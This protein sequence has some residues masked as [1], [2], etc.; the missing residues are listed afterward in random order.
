MLLACVSK[1]KINTQNMKKFYFLLAF[2]FSTA[3]FLNAQIDYY[4]TEDGG[5]IFQDINDNGLV[6]TQGVFFDYTTETITNI[7][8]DENVLAL[9]GYNNAEDCAGTMI[10]DADNGIG[11]PAYR[12][13]G[14]WIP[15]GFIDSEGVGA[16]NTE[17]TA[18]GI[19]ENS[20]Y[21]TGL[22]WTSDFNTF[23]YRYNT[24]TDVM[25]KI[26]N[27]NV[28][29]SN[30]SGYS[31]NDAGIVVGW[32]ENSDDDNFIGRIP[33]YFD[34]TFHYIQPDVLDGGE[35][36]GIN[37][38]N[39]VVGHK[40]G[41]PFIYDIDLD[42]FTQFE[43]PFGFERGEF[44]SI[45]EDGIAVGFASFV[46]T[47]DF[48]P[49]TV[50]ETIIYHPSL[51]NNPILLR[52]ILEAQ[53]ITFDSLDGYL[54]RAT[55]ISPNGNFICGFHNPPA[56]KGWVIN[57]NDSLF[58][59]SDCIIAT[60]ATIEEILPIDGSSAAVDYNLEIEC[61]TSTSDDLQIVQI[62]GLPSG[63]LFPRGENYVEYHLVDGEGNIIYTSTF[64]VNVRD[65]YCNTI[66][67]DLFLVEP[68][69]RVQFEDIDN[70]TSADIDGSDGL[71]YFVEISTDIAQ[72]ESYDITI[73][74]NT[75]GDFDSNITVFV[76]WNQ[77]LI[78]DD[79][80]E[81]FEIGILENSTGTDGQQVVGQIT[82]PS[83]ATMGIT[84]MRVL[85]AFPNSGY[86]I[87]ACNPTFLNY[88]QIEDYTVNVTDA[89]SVN[90][91]DLNTVSIYPNP[92]NDML[93]LSSRNTIEQ[94]SIHNIL[95]Q[96]VIEKKVH[97]LDI[98]VN[99]SSLE[100]GVYLVNVQ[101]EYGTAQSFKVVKD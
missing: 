97:A 100:S 94:V 69:T 35:A 10:F 6:I 24:V 3:T 43:V 44:L 83:D 16:E 93:Y 42:T 40:S 68:I 74:A 54:G 17:S 9:S 46:D 45:S 61:G 82:V 84:R 63:S 27:D 88:G 58:S 71:E 8:A 62:E 90:G 98:E 81:I 19:S 91:N 39:Q 50:I 15:L 92:V 1:L 48:F 78:L 12:K 87:E 56:T 32:S 53:G 52:D 41:K 38:N 85:K 7:D 14:V 95:G 70:V 72:G 20:E 59:E 66:D 26:V 21:V 89:L 79:E 57:L 101:S 76:D 65:P 30:G 99:T 67:D 22:Y 33:F 18:R 60:P 86:F 77:N 29:S 64:N 34:G 49:V 13:D 31:V 75:G 23:P 25:E 37:N 11:Q 80:G 51:G 2:A 4:Q 47:S 36:Y 55:S 96:L 28:V 5:A 73:E